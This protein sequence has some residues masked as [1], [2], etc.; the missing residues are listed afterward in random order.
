MSDNQIDKTFINR[1]I[2]FIQRD[3]ARLHEFKNETFESVAQDWKKY[4]I[5]K[6]L[7]IEIIGRAIDINQHLIRQLAK[8]EHGA[9]LSYAESFLKLVQLKVLPSDFGEIIAQSAGFRNAVVHGYDDLDYEI[10][11]TSIK[12]AVSQYKLYCQYILEFIEP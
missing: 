9:P 1:K 8:P 3:L 12:E 6:N 4:A 11:F 7:M 10:V 5:V 2:S